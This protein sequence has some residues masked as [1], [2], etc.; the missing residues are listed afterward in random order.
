MSCISCKSNVNG[1][2]CNSFDFF[3]QTGSRE[4]L[5]EKYESSS[6]Q[7]YI[8]KE[9]DFIDIS[10]FFFFHGLLISDN[11]IRFLKA[12]LQMNIYASNKMG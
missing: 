3:L 9:A 1:N 2:D 12:P 5:N 8:I 4:G 6:S 10:N 11:L 7:K